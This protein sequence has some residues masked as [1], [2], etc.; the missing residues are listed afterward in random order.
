MSVFVSRNT[1]LIKDWFAKDL[2]FLLQRLVI[3]AVVE[4]MLHGP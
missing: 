3:E 2:F 1:C 4:C